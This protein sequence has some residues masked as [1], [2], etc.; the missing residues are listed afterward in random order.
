MKQFIFYL[1]LLFTATGLEAQNKCWTL[2]ECM[3]YAQ[4]NSSRVRIQ[5]WNIKNKRADLTAAKGA[6]LPSV[7]GSI[8]A[9]ANFGRSINP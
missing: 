1:L 9:D 6:F 3:S 8:G 5:D 4:S 2:D 7:N